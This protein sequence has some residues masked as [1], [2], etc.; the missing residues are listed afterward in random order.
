MLK[1]CISLIFLLLSSQVYSQSSDELP[2]DFSLCCNQNV[3]EVDFFK[4][5]K[6]DSV[7]LIS[8]IQEFAKQ[9]NKLDVIELAGLI[10]NFN[11]TN[12]DQPNDEFI[13]AYSNLRDFVLSD[14]DF[15]TFRLDKQK[16]R[17]PVSTSQDELLIDCLEN[18]SKRIEQYILANLGTSDFTDAINL[19]KV[20]KPYLSN[21]NNDVNSL[22]EINNNLIKW[23]DENDDNK[24]CAQEEVKDDFNLECEYG[25]RQ[26]KKFQNG[27]FVSTQVCKTA[28]E[29]SE[30]DAGECGG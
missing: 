21:K 19:L 20:A 9:P 14:E 24:I 17:A 7:T 13:V 28:E 11:N 4:I 10:V 3:E 25:Y 16:S 23:I 22:V 15:K 5:L 2:F 1:F 27:K 6:E 29:E 30:P 18:L 8:D 26:V 12:S